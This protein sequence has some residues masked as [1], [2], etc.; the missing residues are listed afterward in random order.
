MRTISE[1]GQVLLDDL[2]PYLSE[3]ATVQGVIDTLA[4]EQQRITDVADGVRRTAFPSQADDT[5]KMLSLWE[6]LLGL[7]VKPPGVSDDQRRSKVLATLQGRD[8][9]TGEGWTKAVGQAVGTGWQQAENTP[10]PYQ[11]TVTLPYAAGSYEGRQAANIIRAITPAHIDLLVSYGT[12]FLIDV[13]LI[14][15]DVL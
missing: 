4:R 1:T 7:P 14:G 15:Q 3:D 11:L 6:T 13:S 9:G 2:P 5:Y 8:V 10:G 12:G